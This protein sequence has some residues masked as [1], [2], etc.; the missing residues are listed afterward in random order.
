[1]VMWI[2]CD[3]LSASLK[4]HRESGATDWGNFL[5]STCGAVPHRPG[6][7]RESFEEPP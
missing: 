5:S 6:S 2:S 1:M 7:L 3:D 4:T